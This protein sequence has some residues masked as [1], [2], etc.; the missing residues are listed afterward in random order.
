MTVE[1]SKGTVVNVIPY[2][3]KLFLNIIRAINLMV[4]NTGLTWSRNWE[5]TNL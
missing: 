4:D 5:V 1:R 3:P 2:G